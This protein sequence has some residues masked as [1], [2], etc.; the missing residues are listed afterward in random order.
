MI[1]SRTESRMESGEQE[2]EQEGR[3]DRLTNSFMALIC[4]GGE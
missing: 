1:D 4:K 2:E 3:A